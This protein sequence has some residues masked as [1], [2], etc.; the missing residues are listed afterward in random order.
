MRVYWAAKSKEWKVSEMSVKIG[1]MGAEYSNSME[2]ARRM[3]RSLGIKGAEFAP[4]VSAS[5]VV[6]AILDGEVQFGVFALSNTLGGTVAET[7]EALAGLKYVSVCEDKQHIHHCLFKLPDASTR[8]I[9][10]VASHVQALAQCRRSLKHLLPE[11]RLIETEDTAIAAR[12]LREG[13]LDA[14]TAVICLKAAGE[15]YGLELVAENIEDSE[16][17]ITIFSLIKVLDSR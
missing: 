8:S 10:S 4:L 3:A 9:A 16:Q 15:A 6:C 13:R 7:N 1:V 11:A 5:G 12:N 14:N 17:N 2:A